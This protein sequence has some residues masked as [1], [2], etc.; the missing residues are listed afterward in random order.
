MSRKVSA[1]D[2]K[3]NFGGLLEEVT[4]RGRV[5]IC[6]HGRVVAVVFSPRALEELQRSRTLMPGDDAW[7]R[8]HLIPPA[9]ARAA[10]LLRVPEDFDDD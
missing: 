9:R 1:T 7:G 3:N 6:R 8:T 4:A 5:D 10:R 2:A